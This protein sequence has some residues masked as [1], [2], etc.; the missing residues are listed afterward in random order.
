MFMYTYVCMCIYICI[1]IYTHIT[2][3][4]YRGL[5]SYQYHVG[6]PCSKNSRTYPYESQRWWKD[7]R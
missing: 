4:Y 6:T 7:A 2:Y 3:I 1:Y 5:N